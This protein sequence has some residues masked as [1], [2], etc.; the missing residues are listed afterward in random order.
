MTRPTADEQR[1]GMLRARLQLLLEKI[2]AAKRRIGSK[3]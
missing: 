1:L 3:K 2:I